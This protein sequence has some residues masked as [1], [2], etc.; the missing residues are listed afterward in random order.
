MIKPCLTTNPNIATC[1]YIYIFLGIEKYIS[2]ENLVE[3]YKNE[4]SL[5]T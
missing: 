1:V 4:L 5:N 2:V 3:S